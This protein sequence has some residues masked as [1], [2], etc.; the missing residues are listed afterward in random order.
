MID[1]LSEM[2]DKG[3]PDYEYPLLILMVGVKRE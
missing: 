3:T 1:L 2:M